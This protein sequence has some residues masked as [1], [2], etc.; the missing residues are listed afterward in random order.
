[1]RLG[2]NIPHYHIDIVVAVGYSLSQLAITEKRSLGYHCL[3]LSTIE[4]RCQFV[5]LSFHQYFTSRCRIA[6]PSLPPCTTGD[7]EEDLLA[8]G[9]H[10]FVSSM[11]FKGQMVAEVEQVAVWTGDWTFMMCVIAI[12]ITRIARSSP[13]AKSPTLVIAFEPSRQKCEQLKMHKAVRLY[14]QTLPDYSQSQAHKIIINV[15]RNNNKR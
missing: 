8:G 9:Q 2:L 6:L 10:N 1:M 12:R 15:I 13:G 5:I 7:R 4:I 14:Q 3:P 11:S